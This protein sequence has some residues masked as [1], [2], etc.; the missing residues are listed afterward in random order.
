MK[1][2]VKFEKGHAGLELR[3]V[4]E[5]TPREGELK[6]K[7]LAAGICGSD[8]HAYH[9]NRHLEMPVILGHEFVG[10]VTEGCGDVGEFQVGDWVSTLPA[11]YSCGEC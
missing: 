6:V 2:L 8:N 1:G 11:C 7:V 10:Q 5:P 9:D 3:E 4:P